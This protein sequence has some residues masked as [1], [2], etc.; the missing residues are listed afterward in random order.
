MSV[1]M[2]SLNVV[3]P[4]I[5][6]KSPVLVGRGSANAPASPRGSFGGGSVIPPPGRIKKEYNVKN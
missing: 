6:G 2:N 4:C 1:L 3:D 5:E